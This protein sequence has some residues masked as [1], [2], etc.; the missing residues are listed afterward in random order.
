MNEII[1]AAGFDLKLSGFRVDNVWSSSRSPI[2]K[3]TLLHFMY[4][5]G[6]HSTVG[7]W[8]SEDSLQQPV[9]S[10]HSVSSKDQTLVV[11]LGSEHLSLLSHAKG[12]R[13]YFF[14]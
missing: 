6:A 3:I 7:E 13:V 2:L 14:F 11:T 8:T 10:L 9:L 4:L 5:L 12:S 1:D